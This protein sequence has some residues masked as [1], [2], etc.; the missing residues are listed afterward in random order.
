[1]M[2]RAQLSSISTLEWILIVVFDFYQKSS[3]THILAGLRGPSKL[4]TLVVQSSQLHFSPQYS[5]SDTVKALPS[6]TKHWLQLQPVGLDSSQGFFGHASA[7]VP[8]IIWQQPSP[9]PEPKPQSF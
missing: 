5:R 8:E 7:A 3:P 1:M 9:P 6:T 2:A 4:P